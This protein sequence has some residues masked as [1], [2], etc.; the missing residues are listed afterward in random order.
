MGSRAEMGC[1]TLVLPFGCI[2]IHPSRTEYHFDWD[3]QSIVGTWT[4]NTY[5]RGVVFFYNS[6]RLLY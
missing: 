2:S 4:D 6:Q 5:R 3:L 1:A